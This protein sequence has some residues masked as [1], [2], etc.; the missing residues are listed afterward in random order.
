VHDKQ[1]EGTLT[2]AV[3]HHEALSL[4]VCNAYLKHAMAHQRFAAAAIWV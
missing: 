4:N 2:V 1:G 3:L